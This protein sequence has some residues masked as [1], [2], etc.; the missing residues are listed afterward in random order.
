VDKNFL[1]Y[2]CCVL[3]E[4]QPSDCSKKSFFSPATICSHWQ[5]LNKPG[6][7]FCTSAKSGYFGWPMIRKLWSRVLCKASTS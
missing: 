7:P 1:H 3:W 6:S 4:S 5:Y 2:K